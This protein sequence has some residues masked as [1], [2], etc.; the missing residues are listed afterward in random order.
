MEQAASY[1]QK[2]QALAEEGKYNEALYYFGEHIRCCGA[3]AEVL[4]DMGTVLHCIGRSK[5]AIDCLLRAREILPDNANII[6]NLVEAYLAAGRADKASEYL[7]QMQRLGVLNADVV[8]KAAKIFLDQDNKA[9][10]LEL[11]ILSIRN[12]PV[13]EKI[14]EPMIDCLRAGRSRISFASGLCDTKFLTDII[15]FT[16]ARFPA[17]FCTV[18]DISQLREVM[19]SSDICWFEWC[20]DLAVEASRQPKVC[21]NI[22]R[23]H[24]FE[25]YEKWP[26]QVKWENIDYL[27]LVGNSFVKQTL[28][29]QVP[30]IEQRTRVVTIANGVN[31]D[32]FRFVNRPRGKNLACVGYLNMRKNPMSLLQCMQKLHYIDPQYKLYFAGDFQDGCLEQ[33]IRHITK[34]M[35]LD[36]VVFFDGWQENLNAWL[37]DKHYIVSGSIGESQGMGLLEAMA[38]GLKPVIHNFAGASEIFG[39]EFLFNISEDFCR[40]V[41][42]DNYEPSKY[43]SFVEQRYSL[44]S[45]LKKINKIFSDIDSQTTVFN[46]MD[47]QF[48]Q[49]SEELSSGEFY[50]EMKKAAAGVIKL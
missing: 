49:A 2:G 24:R 6:W 41:L 17:R 16:T 30:D 28:L 20:T 10:A 47:S 43:R 1:Y 50:D 35:G 26:K 8:N 33:Y 19:S 21:K 25:A 23:L 48:N 36:E 13:Q 14:L 29:N 45:E 39:D 9:D 15:D 42:S 18:N 7:N 38:C 34:S 37:A 22:I 3:D 12:W 4:N 46:G 11:L 31:L 27:I 32:K 44:E 5:E 40:Q